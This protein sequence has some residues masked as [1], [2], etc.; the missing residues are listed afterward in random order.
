MEDDKADIQDPLEEVNLGILEDNK[1][2][3]IYA[4][5]QVDFKR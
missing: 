5:L 4:L 2:T 1:P 3:Y